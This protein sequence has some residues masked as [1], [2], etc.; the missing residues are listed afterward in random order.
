MRR[1]L[2][3]F[4]GAGPVF[5][6]VCTVTSAQAQLAVPSASSTLVAQPLSDRTVPFGV[7][8]PGTSKL[9]LWGLDTAWPNENNMRRGV[10]FMGTGNVDVVRASFQPTLPLVNG[11]LQQ[12]QIDDLAYRL[13]LI[14]LSGPNTP[15]TLNCD[16]PSVDSWYL[17]NA[18]RWAQLIDATTRRVQAAGRTVVTVAPFN[19][20]DYGWGQYTGP[21]ANGQTDFF[22]ICGELRANPRFSTIRLSGG[23]TL[24]ADAALPWYNAIKARLNEGNTHQLAGSF[25]SFAN[26]FQAVRADGKY[27]TGDEMHNVMEAMVGV[28]YGMQTG[29]WWGT[30][31][32][33]RGEFVK[34]NHGQRLAYA[35]HRPNWSAASVYRAPDGRVQAFGGTSERQSVTTTYRYLSRDR[36]V[37]Y[38]GVGP[39]REYTLVMPGGTGYQQGQTNA[40][41]VLNVTWGEDIQPAIA[42]GQYM[43]VNRATGQVMQVDGG[44]M[45]NGAN[46]QQAPY[47]GASYQ[48]F[49]VAPVSSRV[50]G[51]F[52]YFSITAVHSGKAIDDYNFSLDNGGRIAQW[53]NVVGVNQQ[54][55]LDY[56]GDGYFRIR[57]RHSSKCL[58]IAAN[59][60]EVVQQAPSASLSQ[61]WRLLPVGTAIEFVAP[62]APSSLAATARPE[63]VR[64]SWAAS[65]EADVAGYNIL[66]AD[67][68][69]GPYN[70]IARKVNATAFVDNTATIARQ[71]FYKVQAVDN[72]LNR[73]GYSN[74]A[75]ATTTATN[76]LVAQ[77]RFDGNTLDSSPNLN[78][79]AAFTGTSYVA[80]K[81]G[82]NALALNGTTAFVQLPATVAN[83]QEITVA[84]WVYWNGGNNWQRIFDFGNDESQ[85]LFLTPKSGN[86]TLRFA[87]KNG[88]AEQLIDAP[89]LP[90]GVWSHVA[91]TLGASG[92]RMYVNGAQV[93]QSTTFTIRPT[94]FMP[95]ANYI[96]RSQYADPLFN[97]RVDDFNVYNYALSAAQIASLAT[98]ST[99]WTGATSTDWY[100]ASNW[101]AGVPTADMDAIVPATAVRNPLIASGTAAVRGL[102]LAGTLLQT[103]GTLDVRG[104]FANNGTFAPTGGTV[105]LGAAGQ[106]TGTG[107]MGSSTSRFW[108]LSVPGSGATLGTAGASV[109][110]VLALTGSLATQGNPFTLESDATGTGMVVNNGGTVT[111][112]ATVQRYLAT[113]L[114]AGAGYR[115]FAAPIST[116]T[117]ASLAT[118]SFAPVVNAAYNSAAA[119]AAVV[120]FPTV[121]GY[122]QSRLASVTNNM[123]AFDKGW[124]SPTALTDALAVGKGYTLNLTAGQTL[125]MRGPLNDGTLSQALTRNAGATAADAGWALVG[126]PYPA[127]LD[128]SQVAAADRPGL[129]AAIYVNE[130][131]GPYTGTYRSYVNGIGGDPVLALGQAFFARVS[132]GQTSGTLTFRN[133]QRLTTY[134]DPALHRPT[135]ETRPLV[136][137]TLQGT[138]S[139]LA[140]H[141]YVYFE[142]G[143]TDGFDAQ[144]DA[145]KLPNPAGLNLSSGFGGQQF[146][147]DGRGVLGT[148]QRVVPLAVGVPAPGSYTL[149][150]AQLL[151]LPGVPVYLR[152]LQTGS[153][154]DLSQQPSYQFTVASAAA[155][156]ATRFELVFSPQQALATAPAALA[157][158]VAL[159]P[160]P[161]T[162]SATLAL[163]AGLGS[164]AGTATLVDALGRTARTLTLPAQ[165]TPTHTLDLRALP[166]GVY[167]LHLRTSAGTIVKK[168]TVE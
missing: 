5:A 112:S 6:L 125:S 161:A 75:A 145:V 113:D 97:G 81:V 9:A 36:D 74:Q 64:L 20:P 137:L 134:A 41:R 63:S 56:V 158:Q 149:S 60:L 87:I 40:E 118:A 153:V 98:A 17:G 155:V 61:Q 37:Y 76:D 57:S 100:A 121:F 73:S 130:S 126:N 50:G 123:S 83:Q 157:Q 2:T 44:S 147:I 154:I 66:R 86:N 16:H 120:P 140:D 39:Q 58:E 42:G 62:S 165:G 88:G 128:Y 22:N 21:A 4:Y 25:D 52:S 162:G 138:A 106:G 94:D 26:F 148:T 8:D 31:E 34:A 78:H 96:G 160:N 99:T 150:A 107:I 53:D 55:Y 70:T 71:Y 95:V 10:F 110:R 65:P 54:R 104:D 132:A 19:E 7:A 116:A 105:S 166:A 38:D 141:T 48:Q 28:E 51:D 30:A 152:D 115:H 68:A 90:T 47:T 119:P 72:S 32:L 43:L 133:A 35:E 168:L 46:L 151:N 1:N 15:V 124:V 146:T 89:T 85:Y 143:A 122:D 92:A 91:V 27:A 102:S 13:Y 101:T 136:Q 139:P 49:N 12:P 3:L 24:N 129:D 156:N 45:S 11:D 77:L 29:I 79:S 108:N 127:P 159:Y 82:A 14:G 144:R 67:A 114:N 18:P 23:N 84:T 103:G 69:A 111:G 33:A 135:A 59:G 164:T 167:A 109:R 80:G 93:A 131:T 142:A 117:V 163:P